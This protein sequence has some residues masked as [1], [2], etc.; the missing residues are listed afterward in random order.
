MVLLSSVRVSRS[1]TNKLILCALVL[2]F[3]CF[4]LVT[5]D[6][7][8]AHK[9][10]VKHLYKFIK[11]EKKFFKV[12]GLEAAALLAVGKM[13]KKKLTPIPLPLPIP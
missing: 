12:K 5:V 10:F 6:G 4:L 3:F 8:K 7:F 13:S 1:T 2:F 11:R 9:K